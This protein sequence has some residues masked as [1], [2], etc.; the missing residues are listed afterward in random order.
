MDPSTLIY[1]GIPKTS[2][3]VTATG[4]VTKNDVAQMANET[5]GT[6]TTES[7]GLL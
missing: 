2:Q 7:D 4:M 6:A 1:Q 3:I 5:T